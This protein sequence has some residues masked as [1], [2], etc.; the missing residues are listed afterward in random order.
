MLDAERIK[1]IRAARRNLIDALNWM[2]ANQNINDRYAGASQ[3]L[4]AFGFLLGCN[5]YLKSLIADPSSERTEMTIFYLDNILPE[6]F[7][8]TRSACCGAS[9]LYSVRL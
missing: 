8:A 5:Y 1:Y 2:I 3:F 7:S 6:M 9:T 4:M